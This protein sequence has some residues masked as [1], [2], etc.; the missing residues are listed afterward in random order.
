[1]EIFGLVIIVLLITLGM[2][3][4]IRFVVF[5]DEDETLKGYMQTQSAANFLS[6]LQ[7][8]TTDC[9]NL[10]IG[11]LIQACA[12]H[13]FKT[14]PSD[15]SSVCDYLEAQLEYILDN[16][17]VAWG[18]KSFYFKADVPG[19]DIIIKNRGCEENSVGD[20]RQELIPTNVG[21]VTIKLRMCDQ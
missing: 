20:L 5:A 6:T 14:C 12:T 4:I 18:N 15:G 1:M 2:F 7:R 11:Q 13:P 21:H 19:N 16:T 17:F 9:N 3:M 10:D 8:T